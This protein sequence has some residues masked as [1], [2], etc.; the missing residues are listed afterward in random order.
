[1]GYESHWLILSNIESGPL[2]SFP[3]SFYNHGVRQARIWTP[4]W[5]NNSVSQ[6][7]ACVPHRPSFP[8]L[9]ITRCRNTTG[10]QVLEST[11]HPVQW[12]FNSTA[13]MMHSLRVQQWPREVAQIPGS[14]FPLQAAALTADFIFIHLHTKGSNPRQA[15]PSRSLTASEHLLWTAFWSHVYQPQSTLGTV[16]REL[17]QYAR[18]WNMLFVTIA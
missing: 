10:P 3:H 17:A 18:I 2:I 13:E 16:E 11:N 9:F 1:M 15:S 6:R 4:L 14:A 8:D 5:V 12:V 7:I